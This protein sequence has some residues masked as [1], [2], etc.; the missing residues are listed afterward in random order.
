MGALRFLGRGYWIIEYITLIDLALNLY[1]VSK[2]NHVKLS[3]SPWGFY[4]WVWLPF[5]WNNL[6]TPKEEIKS[7]IDPLWSIE[8]KWQNVNVCKDFDKEAILEADLS[9]SVKPQQYAPIFVWS[10]FGIYTMHK[11]FSPFFFGD[12]STHN[13]FIFKI[14]QFPLFELQPGVDNFWLRD[15]EE[16]F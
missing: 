3:W 7:E 9:I 6:L 15:L 2:R 12:N 10:T 1:P 13:N 4:C 8:I 11:V 14:S 5:P 16:S